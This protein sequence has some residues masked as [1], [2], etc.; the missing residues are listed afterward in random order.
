MAEATPEEL[1]AV[2]LTRCPPRGRIDLRGDAADAAF[3][4]AVSNVIGAEPPT[5]ANTGL[6]GDDAAILW[7]GPDEWLIEVGAKAE[8]EIARTLEDALSDL[9]ASVA[10]V[11]DGNDTL[12]VAGPRAVDVLAKGMTLDLDPN[13]F[14]ARCCARSLLARAPVLLHR[15]GD[16]LVYEITVARSF[17]DYALHWLRD[18]AFEY[19]RILPPMD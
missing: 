3:T 17:S 15:P 2:T 12:S 9:H 14:P 8:T 13:R 10:I 11:G 7:L 6:P 4:A 18:A 16:G 19:T 5:I 1:P